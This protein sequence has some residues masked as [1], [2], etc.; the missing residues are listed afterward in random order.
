MR[1]DL[2]KF[3]NVKVR[4]DLPIREAVVALRAVAPSDVIRAKFASICLATAF[5]VAGLEPTEDD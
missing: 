4:L 3:G 2:L 1:A 5:V